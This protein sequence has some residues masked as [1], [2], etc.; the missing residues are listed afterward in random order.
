MDPKETRTGLVL[1]ALAAAAGIIWASIAPTDGTAPVGVDF[2]KVAA[3]F[4][5][6]AGVV[7]LALAA[8][9]GRRTDR[10]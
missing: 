4:T 2:L 10:S 9:K 7:S 6:V 3:I 5:A 1:I 8:A